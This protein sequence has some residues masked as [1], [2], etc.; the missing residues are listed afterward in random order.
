MDF[1]YWITVSMLGMAHYFFRKGSSL[2]IR[3]DTGPDTSGFDT[4][5]SDARDS[6]AGEPDSTPQQ[7][8]DPSLDSLTDPLERHR[9][10]TRLVETAYRNRRNSEEDLDTAMT[11]SRKYV[12][13]FESLKPAVFDSMGEGDKIVP[14]FRMLAIM[15]EEAGA[16][17]QAVNICRQALAHGIEDGTRTGFEGRI[18][19]L[20][21][22]KEPYDH[23]HRQTEGRGG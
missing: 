13:E 20:M 2:Q 9:L 23:Q 1:M 15:L 7:Q 8:E 18:K 12:D 10:Y 17:D 14:V 3:P 22:K 16:Y 19:R 5:A 6:S 21:K 4:N 11:L